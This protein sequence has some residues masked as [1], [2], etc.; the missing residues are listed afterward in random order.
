MLDAT[1]TRGPKGHGWT[2]FSG[3]NREQEQR[4]G[5]SFA[6]CPSPAARP[7]CRQAGAGRQL[8]EQCG[9]TAACALRASSGALALRTHC[10]SSALPRGADRASAARSRAPGRRARGL[11]FASESGRTRPPARE[12]DRP[13]LRAP[14]PSRRSRRPEPSPRLEEPTSSRERPAAPEPPRRSDGSARSFPPIRSRR[15]SRRERSPSP[16]P[17]RARA[18]SSAIPGGR[19]RGQAGCARNCVKNPVRISERRSVGRSGTTCGRRRSAPPPPGYE[20]CSTRANLSPTALGGRFRMLAGNAN[21]PPLRSDLA[22][23]SG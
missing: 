5:P 8:R 9:L 19:R 15:G 13:R 4:R 3:D 17:R 10:T 2:R 7:A 11:P 20:V 18:C 22:R 21:A 16:R 14:S 23:L 12:P 1:G 6:G